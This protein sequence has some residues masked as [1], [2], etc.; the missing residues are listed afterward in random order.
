VD[1]GNL[2]VGS[3]LGT[4]FRFGDALLIPIGGGA[5]DGFLSA[6]MA[7]SGS[8]D[9]QSFPYGLPRSQASSVWASTSFFEVL[10]AVRDGAESSVALFCNSGTELIDWHFGQRIF[11]PAAVTGTAKVAS[12]EMHFNLFLM[13]IAG[14]PHELLK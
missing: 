4:F 8:S 2:D 1:S 7:V 10:F 6:V 14:F 11:F 5:F 3:A 13:V 9:C 12:H